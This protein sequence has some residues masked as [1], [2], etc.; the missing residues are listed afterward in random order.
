M[1]TWSSP[2]TS[3]NWKPA[4]SASAYRYTVMTLFSWHRASARPPSC[5]IGVGVGM[6]GGQTSQR[7]GHAAASAPPRRQ[8]PGPTGSEQVPRLP[9]YVVESS[10]STAWHS[11]PDG[12]GGELGAGSPG[13]GGGGEAFDVGGSGGGDGGGG[14]VRSG[15]GDGGGGFAR[16]GEGD[17]GGGL[18]TGGGDGGGGLATGGWGRGDGGGGGRPSGGGTE[19][20]QAGSTTAIANASASE[21]ILF[22]RQAPAGHAPNSAAESTTARRLSASTV[23]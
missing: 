18:E 6:G 15:G 9:E 13:D 21:N 20:P 12:E 2:H 5:G 14:L 3:P 22:V 17:G 19:S 1:P 4:T 16:S 10:H 7:T 11:G 23:I 8:G